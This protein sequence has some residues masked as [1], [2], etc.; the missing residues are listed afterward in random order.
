[1]AESRLMYLLWIVL[2][3]LE[4]VWISLT[5]L[6]DTPVNVQDVEKAFSVE[7]SRTFRFL[8]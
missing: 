6:L 7:Y 4:V 2:M 5:S 8:Y 3:R 1:M